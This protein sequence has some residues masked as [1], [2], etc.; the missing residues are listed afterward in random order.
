MLSSYYQWRAT[1]IPHSL[2]RF[3]SAKIH[4]TIYKLPLF[5]G[6]LPKIT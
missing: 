3:L 6:D 4:K 1:P 2:K 5:M